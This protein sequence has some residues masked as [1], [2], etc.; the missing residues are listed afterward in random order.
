MIQSTIPI[1]PRVVFSRPWEWDEI[2]REQA[3]LRSSFVPIIAVYTTGTGPRA[4][5]L[6]T[7]SGKSSVSDLP[8]TQVKFYTQVGSKKSTAA[9]SALPIKMN[10][11]TDGAQFIE[12]FESISG[13]DSETHLYLPYDDG[14]GY[15]TIGYGHRIGSGE[16]FSKGLTKAQVDQLY[17]NDLGRYVNKINQA[18]KVGVSQNQ[19]DALASICYNTGLS[20][21]LLAV[22]HL[23]A[24]MSVTESDFTAYDN[25]TKNG[26]KGFVAGL[27]KRRKA[28]WMIFSK[29]IYNSAH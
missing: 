25:A 21:N 24:G 26:K 17:I 29:N 15:P 16:D 5:L 11:S 10:L 4:L 2:P 7:S 3:L 18:L 19:F 28:E 22:K 9:K 23:N 27:L 6:S 13:Y 1:D 20:G 12:G 8:V 14:F